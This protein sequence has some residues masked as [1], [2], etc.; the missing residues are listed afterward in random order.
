MDSIHHPKLNLPCNTT[1]HTP[2]NAGKSQHTTQ[3][4]AV[5][6]DRRHCT[7]HNHKHTTTYETNNLLLK[8]EHTK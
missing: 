4:Q 3:Q 7:Q 1:P 8:I 6:I 5:H 2:H